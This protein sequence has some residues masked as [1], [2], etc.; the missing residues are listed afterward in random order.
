MPFN[1]AQAIPVMVARGEQLHV[2]GP[3][4]SAVTH[5]QVG[6]AGPGVGVTA[7]NPPNPIG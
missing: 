7:S 3:R 6:R 2:A 5:S 1:P 4:A